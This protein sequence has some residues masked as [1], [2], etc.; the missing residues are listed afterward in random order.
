MRALAATVIAIALLAPFAGAGC[1]GPG[2][3]FPTGG[4]ADRARGP[5]RDFVVRRQRA[6]E[7]ARAEREREEREAASRAPASRAAS[8][9]MV[10]LVDA[11]FVWLAA[12]I[13][14]LRLTAPGALLAC[15]V[16][17]AIAAAVPGLA[18]IGIG[19]AVFAAIAYKL[20]DAESVF[21]VLTVVVMAAILA[22]LLRHKVEDAVAGL[23]DRALAAARGGRAL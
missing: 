17:T 14:G 11:L 3:A 22:I 15:A 16:S 5:S 9:A 18:G 4:D 7:R 21:E 10:A 23:A 12:R 2:N 13:T 1:D 20:A 6:A 8:L 19:L